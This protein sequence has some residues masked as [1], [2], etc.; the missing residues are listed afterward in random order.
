MDAGTG[1]GAHCNPFP[2]APAGL[3]I[4]RAHLLLS[5]R[6]RRKV[7][8]T[9]CTMYLIPATFAGE[10]DMVPGS[11]DCLGVGFSLFTVGREGGHSTD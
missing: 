11:T 8:G 10:L 4:K 6:E 3:L 1:G 9:H 2:S 7:V 5:S